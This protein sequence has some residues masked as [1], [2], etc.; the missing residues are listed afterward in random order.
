[1]ILQ[2]E[3]AIVNRP[4]R[5]YSIYRRPAKKGRDIYY[6]KFRDPKTSA[7]NVFRSTGC[8]RRDDAVIW[9][10]G[11]LSEQRLKR[12]NILF[13]KYVE[14][15]WLP[16][17][18]YAQAKISRGFTISPNYLKIAEVYTRTH[19]VPVFGTSL[20][21]DISTR[22]IDAW[23]VERHKANKLAPAT[24]NRLLQHLKTILGQAAS[25][26]WISENP[27]AYVRPVKLETSE[28]GVLSPEEISKLLTPNDWNDQRHYVLNL[29][30][31]A[32][33]MRLGEI[34]G[35]LVQ[36]LHA[37]RIEIRHNWQDGEG[38]KTP[39]LGSNRSVPISDR[40]FKAVDQLL[41]DSQPESIVFYGATKETP[42]PKYT[43]EWNFNQALKRIGID[44]E[45]RLSRNLS[46]H[47]WRHSMNTIL[48]SQGIVDSKVRRVTGHRSA[49]MSDHYTHFK[50]DDYL[51]VA[52]VLEGVLASEKS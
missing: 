19:L 30:A 26:S 11:H 46:F 10:E 23:V 34:R 17:G 32:T 51:D 1:M 2:G 4:K 40:I 42:L 6:A 14:G 37:D 33:G 12:E 43:I 49:L 35:L 27:A 9:C 44:K 13:E 16:S 52:R 3:G 41:H 36:D 29:L 7:Y 25:E 45:T 47:S 18:A 21:R 39:K 28:K 31:Y 50:A 48:R 5:P 8:R 15:F 20:L 38:L 24:I 22:A